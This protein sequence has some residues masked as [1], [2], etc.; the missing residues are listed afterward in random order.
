MTFSVSNDG[1]EWSLNFG[2]DS[3]TL[4]VKDLVQ[5]VR[6]GSYKNP[7]AAWSLSLLQ[8]QDCLN[9]R[10]ARVPFTPNLQRAMEMRDEV[11]SC[12]GAQDLD[13]SGYRATDLNDEKFYWGN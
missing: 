1:I 13:T 8:R 4:T 2:P 10:I 11:L 12:V 6:I 9:N 3:D 7:Q 5:K